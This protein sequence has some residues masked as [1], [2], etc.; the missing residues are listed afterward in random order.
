MAKLSDYVF[1]RV[2]DAGVR[3]VFMLPGGGCMHLVDSLGREKRLAF[4]CNLHEQACAVAADAYAQYTGGLGAALVTTG[5]GGTN[6]VTGVAGS[7]LDSI[8][9]LI[10]SGQVKR[11]DLMDGRG[12]RQMGFQEINIV[13]IVRPIT[14]Y[15][16]KIDDPQSIRYHFEKAVYL[17]THGR[18]GPVWI[19]I[20]LD[21]QA[22]E[23]DEASLPSFDPSELAQPR[24]DLQP[25]AA[26]AIR[27]LNESERP[28]VLVGNGVRLA[29]AVEPFLE[30]VRLLDIPVLTTWKAMDL[31]A[32][33]DPRYIGRPGAVGQRAAN[34][35]QQNADCLLTLGARLDL[36]QTAYNHAAFARGARKIIVDVDPA[37]IRKLQM[38]IDLPVCGDAG[39]FLRAMLAQDDRIVRKPRAAWWAK[40]R[41]WKSRFPIILP[42]Y[43]DETDGV[44]NYVLVDVIAESMRA[45]D[46]LIPGS[47]GGS[48][49]VTMQA[50]RVP[51]GVRV[52]N[53]EGLGPMG[54][55]LPAAIGGCIASGGR[56]TVCIDGDGGVQMNI[57][58][59][60]T[61]HRLQLPLK[62]FVLSNAGYASIQSTQRTYF[63]GR[64]VA[65]S[66]DS[67]LS[68]PDMRKIATAYGLPTAE[69]RDHANIRQ[70]VREIMESPGPVVCDVRISPNQRTAPRVSSRQ[71][72][73]GLME[74]APM[75][76]LWP[77]LDREDFRKQMFI[78]TVGP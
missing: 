17:A 28:V 65:S 68:L 59:L 25:L 53:T 61:L 34:F 37:E 66:F 1:Q 51:A 10:V 39:D 71:R 67:G 45:G 49:E 9:V 29:G 56:R 13:D 3:H 2:A 73:D 19:D 26:E 74:S 23:I 50:F 35:A 60:E 48:S 40:C 24:P 57:Q 46:V 14:K 41:E 58:E 44:N 47:S 38:T 6:A 33:D 16:V 64:Y 78:S 20:P 75:E 15:A 21:V 54:F 63:E 55:G 36:G 30:L 22:A 70:Q 27:L 43:W 52:F 77:F 32:E 76:D 8:P 62:L 42:E 31:L 7:W 69:I 72:P 5:P 4:T 18:R 12:V 11:P